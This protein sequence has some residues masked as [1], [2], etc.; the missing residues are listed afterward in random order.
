MRRRA[1]PVLAK[2]RE[3]VA[4]LV[5]SFG[6]VRRRRN[7]DSQSEA[8]EQLRPQLPLLG[9]PAADEDETRRVPNA[10]SFALDKVFTR[11][12]DIQQQVDN[13]VFEQVDLV[14]I[15][16]SPVGTS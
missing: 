2:L 16:E 10:E 12:G 11:G 9:I 13:V 3:E 4:E 1:E 14:D 5:G 6:D 15:E 7:L 8:I